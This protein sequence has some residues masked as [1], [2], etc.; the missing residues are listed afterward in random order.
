MRFYVFW[1]NMQPFVGVSDVTIEQK[2]TNEQKNKQKKYWPYNSDFTIR[3]FVQI[4]QTKSTHTKSTV[5]TA[6]KLFKIKVFTKSTQKL[7]KIFP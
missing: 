6:Q 2:P 7:H 3:F 5:I 4:N 1:D